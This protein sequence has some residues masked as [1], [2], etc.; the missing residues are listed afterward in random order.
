MNHVKIL[1]WLYKSK[2]N[3]EGKAPIYL[4]ITVNGKKVE[5]ATGHWLRTD[6]WDTPKQKAKGVSQGSISINKYITSTTNKILQIQDS[7]VIT[8]TPVSAELIKEKLLGTTSEKKTL[9]QLFDYH[10]SQIK[11]QVGKDFKPGTHKHYVVTRNK[12][13]KFLMSTYRASDFPLESLSHEFVTRFE[14][15]LKTVEGLSNNTAMKK[16][17]QLKKIINL[18][19]AHGWIP[20]NPFSNFRCTYKDPQREAL[21][22]EEINL[23][24]AKQFATERLTSVRDIFLFGCYTGLRFSDIQKLTPD[25]IVNGIDGKKWLTIDTVKTGQRCNIPLLEPA[26]QLIGKYS[27]NPECLNKGVLFP[28]RSNQ[29]MNDYLKEIADVTGIKKKLHFHIARHTFATTVTLA[30]GVS[31]ETVG[32][33]LGHTNNRTTQIYA[34]MTPTRISNEMKMV[35]NKLEVLAS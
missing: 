31:L 35:E 4:R 30:N 19:L 26:L 25:N 1:F 21:T 33:M 27:N 10:N 23:L 18:A 20:K 2:A 7:L 3:K 9:L 16:I 6:E 34:K 32:K 28:V 22:K 24:A 14:V 12:V 13:E 29:K 8:E 15:Y 11:L 5:I 17:K